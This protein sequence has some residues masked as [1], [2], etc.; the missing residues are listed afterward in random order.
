MESKEAKTAALTI[1][2]KGFT[3]GEQ[4]DAGACADTVDSRNVAVIDGYSYRAAGV[5]ERL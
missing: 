5:V 4:A 2:Q 3:N 1:Q